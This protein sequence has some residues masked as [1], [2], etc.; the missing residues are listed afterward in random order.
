[1]ATT[2]KKMFRGAAST[3]ST[4]LYTAPSTAG[5]KAV[6]TSIVVANTSSSPATYSLSVGGTAIA[7]TVTVAAND[8]A[9]LGDIKI[10]MDASE[11]ITGL[12]SSTSV[13]F[14][15]SGVEIV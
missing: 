7:T 12:A 11:T 1:M 15:I 2:V 9:V 5:N 3:T 4:T 13:N 10:V 14:I 8:S 6:I